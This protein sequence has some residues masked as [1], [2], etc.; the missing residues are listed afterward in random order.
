MDASSES[1]ELSHLGCLMGPAQWVLVEER[2]LRPGPLRVCVCLHVSTCVC[3]NVCLCV[4]MYVHMCA[5]C[6]CVCV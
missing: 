2:A 6:L 5:L 4:H 1:S 3:M